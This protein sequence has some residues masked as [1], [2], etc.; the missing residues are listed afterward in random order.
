MF[1]IS[2]GPPV[3]LERRPHVLPVVPPWA[4]G[5][6]PSLPH[7]LPVGPPLVGVRLSD[8]L[9]GLHVGGLH[10]GVP[11]MPVVHRHARQFSRRRQSQPIVYRGPFDDNTQSHFGTVERVPRARHA[12]GCR[13]ASATRGAGHPQSQ[14]AP[15]VIRTYDAP[16]RPGRAMS[17]HR[18]ASSKPVYIP[19]CPFPGCYENADDGRNGRCCGNHHRFLLVDKAKNI[20]PTCIYPGCNNLARDGKI[21]WC[22]SD[23]HY[24][25]MGPPKL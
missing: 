25:R 14:S 4:M 11:M 23:E 22:C 16:H 2:A 10:V 21:G 12:A 6:L 15:F 5:E 19:Q 9:G 8:S 1:G 3:I 24:K 20:W 13:T 7:E 17:A 18:I